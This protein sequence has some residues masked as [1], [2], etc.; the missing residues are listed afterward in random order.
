MSDGWAHIAVADEEAQGLPTELDQLLE[1]AA[2]PFVNSLAILVRVIDEVDQILDG[3][4][5]VLLQAL[6]SL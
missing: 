5:N 3:I 4:L 2:F 1:G 6:G